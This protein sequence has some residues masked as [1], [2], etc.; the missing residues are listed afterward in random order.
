MRRLLR[1]CAPGRRPDRGAA[2]VEAGLVV[3]VILIPMVVGVL[4]WGDYF[5]KAQQVDTVTPGV[6]VGELADSFTCQSL[7]DEIAA[8]VSAVVNGLDPSLGLDAS[9]VTV[10]V[11][12]VL[13]DVGVTVNVH[14]EVPA[15]DGLAD[16]IPLPGGGAIVTDFTQRLDDVTVSDVTCR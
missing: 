12:E 3:S 16:L 2:A 1:A 8:T 4:Q 7:K 14:I 9:N 6:P 11:V 15:A 13:P 10:T 5:W